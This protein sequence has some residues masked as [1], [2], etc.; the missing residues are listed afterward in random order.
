MIGEIVT[1]LKNDATVV[2]PL[3]LQTSFQFSAN[4]GRDCPPLLWTSSTSR[5]RNETPVKDMDFVTIQ[6]SSY[7]DNPRSSYLISTYV[8]NEL[9]KYVGTVNGEA[10]EIRFDDLE[11]GM[12][13]EDETFITIAEFIVTVKRT[14]QGP[15]T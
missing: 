13:E 4:K 3:G 10:I 14:A 1:I 2:G 9:D 6:V 12:A 5:Q 8:R 15:H 11:T 7:D